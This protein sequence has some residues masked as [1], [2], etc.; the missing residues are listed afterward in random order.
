MEQHIK[1][2]SLNSSS[3]E[4]LYNTRNYAII[5]KSQVNSQTELASQDQGKEVRGNQ[6]L[7]LVTKTDE[8]NF[9][10]LK[11]VCLVKHCTL[12]ILQLLNQ[13]FLIKVAE[14]H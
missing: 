7:V 5:H 10:Q 4:V 1:Y 11:V 3:K 9:V 12:Q 14:E 8:L 6:V 13:I 2:I